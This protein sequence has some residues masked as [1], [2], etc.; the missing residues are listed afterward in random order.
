MLSKVFEKLVVIVDHLEKCGFFLISSIVS[1]L[2]DQLQF[3][4]DL[5]KVFN[6]PRATQ[7]VELDIYKALN[8]VWQGPA[9]W[10]V[11]VS[12]ELRYMASTIQIIS[13]TK[14]RRVRG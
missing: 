12:G 5:G 14:V 8:R 11:T 6:R 13:K 7:A 10:R 9:K 2:L 3:Y 1:G 4:Q